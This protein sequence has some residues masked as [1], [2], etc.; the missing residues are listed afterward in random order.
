MCA[1]QQFGGK[2]TLEKLDILSNYLDFYLNAL[3]NQPFNKIYIDAFAGSGNI[4][5]ATIEDQIEGS[6]RLALR[7]KNKFDRY[8]FVEHDKESSN[9]LK[10]IIFDEFPSM[11]DRVNIYCDDCNDRLIKICRDI[12]WNHNR[13][14]LFL[15]P[16]AMDVKWNTLNVVASTSS[17]DVWYLFPISATNRL[18][19]KNGEIEPSWREKL[20]SIFGDSGWFDEF[21]EEDPQMSFFDNNKKRYIKTADKDT[22]KNYI[23][24]R[25]RTIFPEVANNPR[26][27]YNSKNSPIF[28]FCFAVSNP[29]A[30]KLA[31]KGANHILNKEL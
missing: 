15:D 6:A 23:L 2:W 17:V 7:A 9:K 31:L 1:K 11:N 16:C 30:I 18:L 22:L 24:R 13:A 28:L 25:L 29:K 19:K 3:K 10:K 8:I 4:E 26:M 5:S 21:Y 14:L 27:L 20:D 12:N